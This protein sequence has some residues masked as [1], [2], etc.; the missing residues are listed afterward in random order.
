MYLSL[1]IKRTVINKAYQ[2]GNLL[3]V[4]LVIIVVMLVLGL[5]LVRILSASSQQNVIEY[6]GSRAYL[7]AQSG[8]ESGLTEIFPLNSPALN[9]A[10]VTTSPV[11][12]T[13][14]LENCTV[15][16]TCQQYL[17]VPDSSNSAGS[18][19]VFYLQSRAT[20]SPS[21]CAIGEACRKDYWQTQRT[22]SVEAKTLP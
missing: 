6:Y 14:Y 10:A 12:Q 4:T 22:L 7:A 16:I 19:N 13:Q 9:C 8:L 21:S 20:C 17:N 11:F 2:G 3:I 15:T 18:V 5:A 1:R